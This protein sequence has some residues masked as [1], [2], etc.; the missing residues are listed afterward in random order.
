M[1]ATRPAILAA[2]KA[3]LATQVTAV[4]GKVYLPWDAIPQPEPDKMLQIE[5]ADTTINPD[6][7][8]GQWEH[9][10]TA[11]IGAVVKGKFDIQAAWDLMAAS[12]TGLLTDLSLGG[13]AARIDF[14]RAADHITEAGDRILWPHIELQ[15]I[16]RT[17]R[18]TL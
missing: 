11:R 15:I 4:A 17:T 1:A 9:V 14:V 3:L 12:T 2:L 16:Y 5:V 7:I 13:L 8:I 10:I 18:G 6:A